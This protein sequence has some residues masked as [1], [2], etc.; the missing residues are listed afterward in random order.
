LESSNPQGLSLS[1]VHH[2]LVGEQQNALI[3]I[4]TSGFE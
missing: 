4:F 3:G 2:I 1:A